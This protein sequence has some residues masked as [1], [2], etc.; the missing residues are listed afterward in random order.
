MEISELKNEVAAAWESR[1]SLNAAS[2]GRPRDAV[3]ATL[4]LLD[5]GKVRVAEKVDGTWRV[6]DWLKK[7]VLLSFRLNDMTAVP[8]GPGGAAW[9]DKVPPKFAGWD[10]GRFR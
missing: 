8:G 7:A 6:N 4:A 5:Q 3:T 9:W 10:D 1:D 2:R